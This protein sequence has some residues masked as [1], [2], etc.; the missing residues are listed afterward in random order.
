MRCPK[1]LALYINGTAL[2][3]CYIVKPVINEEFDMSDIIAILTIIEAWKNECP[4][5]RLGQLIVNAFTSE[6]WVGFDTKLF[7]IKDSDLLEKM[8]K[9]YKR[10]NKQEEYQN[11][12][13][14]MF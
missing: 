4:D 5:L 2:C 14:K 8:R 9:E 3:D 10:I 11:E 1:C 7:Y 13:S 6:E 12:L